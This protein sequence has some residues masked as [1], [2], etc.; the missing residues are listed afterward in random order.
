MKVSK[1]HL[2]EKKRANNMIGYY[3]DYSINGK[4][5]QQTLKDLKIYSNP[6]TI[7][8]RNHNK[9]IEQIISKMVLDKE[10]ELLDKQYGNYIGSV[11]LI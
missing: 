10:R 8:Q 9:K 1:V 11:A 5:K 3:L 6:K 4:R 2:R 7:S